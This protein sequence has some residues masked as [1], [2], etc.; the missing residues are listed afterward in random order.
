MT[1]L[2]RPL[3]LDACQ[4]YVLRVA[5][6]TGTTPVFLPVMFISYQP[7]PALVIV[8]LLQENRSFC[9]V[10]RDDLFSEVIDSSISDEQPDRLGFF[11]VPHAARPGFVSAP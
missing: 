10:P 9:K 11:L 7:C 6:A 1:L 3:T 4:P 5:Q 8:S 2:V